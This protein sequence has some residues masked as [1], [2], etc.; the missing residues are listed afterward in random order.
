[1]KPLL[2][3]LGAMF[4]FPV[5]LFL[6][7]CKSHDQPKASFQ[8]DQEKI[9]EL[10]KLPKTQQLLSNEELTRLNAI[11]YGLIENNKNLSQVDRLLF[12][13]YLANSQ[14][15]FYLL[16]QQISGKNLGSF[17]PVTLGIIQL[18][19]PEADISALQPERN[20]AYSQILAEA[21]LEKARERFYK[22]KEGLTNYQIRKEPQYWSSQSGYFG[23]SF[24]SIKPWYMENCTEYK[25]PKPVLTNLFL[26]EQLEEVKNQMS[27]VDEG[28]LKIIQYWAYD[29]DWINIADEYMREKNI[30]LEKR[31][32]ARS[33]LINA[34]T[35]AQ[36]AVFDSK[37]S[38]WIKRPEMLDPAIQPLIATPNHPSY[39]SGHSAIG[40]TAATVLS[41]FFPE[42]KQ[43]WEALAN[44]AGMSR[45]WAGLHYPMDHE[46][47]VKL[48]EKVGNEALQDAK[49]VN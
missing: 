33:V 47:G 46:E 12:Y 41:S 5:L 7:G 48:G 30:D 25:C 15:D 19:H 22:E 16:T 11:A 28:K 27:D 26:R 42:N 2:N 29:A 14:K 9:S 40:K 21:V 1:M 13:P 8:F 34:I 4:L 24:G 35:D 20:E 23:L 6:G 38:Y 36:G 18:F 31:L 39:P 43:S 32:A 3:G 45:I 10:Q 17:S 49:A 44:E 37:Y